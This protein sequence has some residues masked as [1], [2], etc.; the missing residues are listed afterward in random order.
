MKGIQAHYFGMITDI[1]GCSNEELEVADRAEL[2]ALLFTKYPSLKHC[3]F[4][5]AVN[6]QIQDE[7][8]TLKPGDEV[9][10]LP[11]FSGG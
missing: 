5:I 7:N 8:Y 11:P 3:R 2:E 1:T 10:L 6:Q 4:R 9:A